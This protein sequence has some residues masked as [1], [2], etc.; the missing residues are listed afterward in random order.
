M[1]IHALLI[2]FVAAIHPMAPQC[3]HAADVVNA[4]ALAVASDPLPPVFASREAD[5]AVL[6]YVAWR[7][8]RFDTHA[9]GDGGKSRGAWQ[10]GTAAGRADTATQARAAL[11]HLHEDAVAC[12]D[13]PLAAYKSGN[14]SHGRDA[15]GTWMRA[16]GKLLAGLAPTVDATHGAP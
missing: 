13:L 6:T 4:V 15:A 14:C 7:E 12:R 9:S 8:S 2:A 11:A 1:T 3:G 5:A 16:A 10:L